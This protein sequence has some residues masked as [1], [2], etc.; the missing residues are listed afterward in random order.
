MNRLFFVG[1]LVWV[2]GL[3]LAGGEG[4]VRLVGYALEGIG[5][6]AQVWGIIAEHRRLKAVE[7]ELADRLSAVLDHRA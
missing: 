3:M 7:R 1:V 4:V 5:I 6:A 2:I